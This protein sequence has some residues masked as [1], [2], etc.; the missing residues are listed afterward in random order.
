M[1][2]YAALTVP[3]Q[4]VEAAGIRFAYRR[5]GAKIRHPATVLHALYRFMHFP[6]PEDCLLGIG[7]S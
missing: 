7:R 6:R 5:F 4:F 2:I 1:S 3:A